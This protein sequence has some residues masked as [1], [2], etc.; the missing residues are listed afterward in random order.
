MFLNLFLLVINLE[1]NYPNPFN[2]T[3]NIKFSIPEKSELSL[4][5]YNLV[6]QEV[7]KLVNNE[8]FNAGSYTAQWDG[9]NSYGSK[10]ASGIYI[11]ELSA[12]KVNII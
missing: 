1:Q 12:G 3:T 9:T 4:T 7:V 6:G 10:V 11:Y 5:I 2:P 8:L